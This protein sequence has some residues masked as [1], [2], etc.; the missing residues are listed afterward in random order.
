MIPS[1]A[2]AAVPGSGEGYAP[3]VTPLAGGLVNR[4][5]RVETVAGVFVLRL[6]ASARLSA[7]LGVD[8]RAEV[9]AQRLAGAAGLAPRVIAVA[10][11]HAFQVCEFVAGGAAGA[12]ELASP[13]GMARLGAT[14]RRLR[15]LAA[16]GELR[17]ADLITRT[18]RLVRLA[19]AREPGVAPALHAALASAEAGWIGAGQGR[20]PCLVH[21]DPNPGNVVL[22]AG[23]AP[24]VL[25]DWEYA[26]VGD[27]LQDPA[28]WLQACPALRGREVELLRAC[29][30]EGEADAAMLA[31][32][33]A[34]YAALGFA[35]SRLVETAAG[36]APDG[37]A[38]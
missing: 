29:G 16:P 5:F 31:G 38:N 2:L 25:L 24:A 35:W 14:L 18:R 22:A 3:R 32:L 15:T 9:A 34:V 4:A 6:N 8:R 36:V 33:S 10:P 27:P 37:R 13:S 7:L 21:S 11:D 30:L 20:Q 19:A 26:H 23:S 17:G 28:A 12:R 1:Q